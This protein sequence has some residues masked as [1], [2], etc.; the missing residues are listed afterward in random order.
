MPKKTPV[1]QKRDWLRRFETGES[2]ADIAKSEGKG[3]ATIQRG[4]EWARNERQ[5]TAAHIKLITK[6]LQEHQDKLMK[7]I[8][9]LKAILVMPS[10]ELLIHRASEGDAY[11][12]DFNGIEQEHDRERGLTIRLTAE[13]E[14]YWQLL[15]EHFRNKRLESE[16]KSWKEAVLD[17]LK[18]GSALAQRAESLL[19]VKTGLKVVEKPVTPPYLYRYHTVNILCNQVIYEKM[20]RLS[21]KDSKEEEK[22]FIENITVDKERGIVVYALASTMAGCPGKEEECR[23]RIIE[24][25]SELKKSDLVDNFVKSLEALEKPMLKARRILDGIEL[26]GLIPRRC[27]AC[28]SLG[29]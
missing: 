19:E 24:A 26:I 20:A 4:I 6:A 22:K 8:A 21:E 17:Y 1:I 12:I 2:E 5:V 29:L 9:S 13:G 14:P 18:A 27:H 15:M 16:I 23:E 3:L 25:Y 28:R 10:K 7:L 11:Q